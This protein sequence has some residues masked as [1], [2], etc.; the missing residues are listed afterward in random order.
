MPPQ[1]ETLMLAHTSATTNGISDLSACTK[2]NQ[3]PRE[4]IDDISWLYPCQNLMHA[5][6]INTSGGRIRS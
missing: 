6:L 3:Q 5:N 4:D 1:L 2:T